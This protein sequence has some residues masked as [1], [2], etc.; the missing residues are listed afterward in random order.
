MCAGVFT[1][2]YKFRSLMKQLKVSQISH[3]DTSSC[4]FIPCVHIK[5]QFVVFFFPVGAAS[6][7][8]PFPMIYPEPCRVYLY[9][10]DLPARLIT[11]RSLINSFHR[12]CLAF[13]SA[14]S[15]PASPRL[16]SL[17]VVLTGPGKMNSQATP[18]D[19]RLERTAENSH[20]LQEEAEITSTV[21]W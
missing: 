20:S 18:Q 21:R 7:C 4:S 1:S 3:T 13:P 8:G 9:S 2:V 19:A 5:L 12:H 16:G 15:A 6:A 14:T 17:S 10:V 11:P